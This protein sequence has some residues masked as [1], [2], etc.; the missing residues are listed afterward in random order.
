MSFSV[1]RGPRRIVCL[2]EE[3][4]EIL[5]R[6][7]EGERIV[8]ISAYT[9]RPP[10][11]RRD[12]PV[13]SAF[14]GGS[15]S[16]ICALQPDL[17]IGFSDIQADLARQLIQA[18]LPVLI[19]NQRSLQEILDVI[20]DVG[21]LVDRKVEAEALVAGYARRLEQLAGQSARRAVRPRVYFEEWDEPMITAIRWVGELIELAGGRNVFAE[22]SLGKLA[23]ERF[24]SVEDVVRED[25]EVV[26]AS[27]CG[28]PFDRAAFESRPGF[29]GLAAVRAGRVQ[30]IPSELILQPGPA[31]LTDGLDLLL[32]ALKD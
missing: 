30:E 15:V 26:L 12:K 11:A 3:P 25:P 19:F 1:S 8:G 27:W 13:V 21:R 24:V 28:K 2:T 4:T 10:E 22:R 16:K 32:H 6:L 18:N 29:S 5:Y 31:C 20:V 14:I 17:V 9:V 7:G 23:R